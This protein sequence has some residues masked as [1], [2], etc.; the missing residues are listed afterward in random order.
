MLVRN[1]GKQILNLFLMLAIIGALVVAAIIILSLAGLFEIG[2][3]AGQSGWYRALENGELIVLLIIALA[4]AL[5]ALLGIR[6]DLA[7]RCS[8]VVHRRGWRT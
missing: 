7:A 3:Q 2:I 5:A 6:Q 8:R 1:I 4:V